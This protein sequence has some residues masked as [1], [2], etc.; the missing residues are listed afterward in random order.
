M[1][2]GGE[3]G[4]GSHGFNGKWRGVSRQQQSYKGEGGLQKVVNFPFHYSFQK[5]NKNIQSNKVEVAIS[6]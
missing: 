6:I 4:G 2:E 3:F 1:M 5:C